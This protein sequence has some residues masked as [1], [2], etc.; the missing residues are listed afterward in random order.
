MAEILINLPT[1]ISF[2]KCINGHMPRKMLEIQIQK[3]LA[4]ILDL[5]N[6]FSYLEVL[7]PNLSA[8]I[9]DLPILISYQRDA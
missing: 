5:P 6:L 7:D 2:Q 8:E 3:Y 1:L 9:L 4:E